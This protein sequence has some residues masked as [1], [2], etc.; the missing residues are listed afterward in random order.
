MGAWYAT[1][2]AP[3]THKACGGGCSSTLHSSCTACL[4]HQ[5]EHGLLGCPPVSQSQ[6]LL[7]CSPV[8]LSVCL[9]VCTCHTP[10][11]LS[12]CMYCLPACVSVCLSICVYSLYCMP[13][14]VSVCLYVRYASLCVCL[15]V[16]LCVL[17]VLY[18][19]LCV[20][21]D[22]HFRWL[23]DNAHPTVLY[24]TLQTPNSNMYICSGPYFTT[25]YGTFLTCSANLRVVPD[26]QHVCEQT[27]VGTTLYFRRGR[28][29]QYI[30]TFGELPVSQ[31][32]L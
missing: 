19:S 1:H 13:A 9:C 31:W 10:V 21:L 6:C 18:G 7:A 5:L 16:H 11:C 3:M 2:A 26:I 4:S 27:L 12:V 14:C 20:C 25:W 30:H 32:R 15:S 23:I 29:R 24:N 17:T 8:C 28:G 22:S